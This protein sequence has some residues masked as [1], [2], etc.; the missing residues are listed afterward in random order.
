MS[1]N[2]VEELLNSLRNVINTTEEYDPENPD[3]PVTSGN[4]ASSPASSLNISGLR[5]SIQSLMQFKNHL[6]PE[7][8]SSSLLD[9]QVQDTVNHN[10]KL[11]VHQQHQYSS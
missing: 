1:I 2:Q 8:S 10:L 3:V 9:I 5:E 11:G 7:R 6:I 4:A